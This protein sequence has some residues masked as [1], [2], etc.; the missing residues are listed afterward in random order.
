MSVHLH[1]TRV[2]WSKGRTGLVKLRGKLIDI[3]GRQIHIPGLP[4]DITYL[5]YTPQF[6]G[7]ELRERCDRIRLLEDHEIKKIDRWLLR[8][9]KWLLK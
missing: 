2:L 1:L 9:H 5:D 4:K 6:G 7:S 8:V 3:G